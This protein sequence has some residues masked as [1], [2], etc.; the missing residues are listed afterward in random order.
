MLEMAGL[1]HIS[2]MVNDAQRTVTFYA[3]I[4]GVRLVMPGRT[5]IIFILEMRQEIPAAFSHFFH[6][7]DA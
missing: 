6:Q 1:H 2:A 5:A 7:A 3:G 4:V